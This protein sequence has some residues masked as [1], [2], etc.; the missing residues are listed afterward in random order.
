MA[1]AFSAEPTDPE[2]REEIVSLVRQFTDEQV[3]PQAEH[4]DSTDTWP[5]PI[6]EG[7]KELGLFGVTLPE[8][9]GG[10]GEQAE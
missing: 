10:I 1:T 2:V 9:Y 3:I 5:E 4:Y 8:E 7:L 6:V